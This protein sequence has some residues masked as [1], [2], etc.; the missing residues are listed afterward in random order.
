MHLGTETLREM[1]REGLT[2][3]P[4]TVQIM[5]HVTRYIIYGRPPKSKTSVYEAVHKNGRSGVGVGGGGFE[6]HS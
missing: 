3:T 4:L 5:S 6:Q 1:F 2:V